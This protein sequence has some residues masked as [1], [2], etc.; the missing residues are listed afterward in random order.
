MDTWAPPQ[1]TFGTTGAGGPVRSPDTGATT[2]GAGMNNQGSSTWDGILH[3]K[4]AG[5]IVLA[6]VL[7]FALQALG[8][9]FVVAAGVGS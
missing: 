6:L 5:T 1:F 7:V 3:Y 4:I 2:G 9:R 8:F